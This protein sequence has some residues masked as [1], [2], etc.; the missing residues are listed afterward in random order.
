MLIKIE[1]ADGSVRLI[2]PTERFFDCKPEELVDKTKRLVSDTGKCYK[3]QVHYGET[4]KVNINNE[5]NA[6][7]LKPVISP[8][9][10]I[11]WK[12]K[13]LKLIKAMKKTTKMSFEIVSRNG[14]ASRIVDLKNKRREQKRKAA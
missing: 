10:Y 8:S 4:L 1:F 14:V 5:R 3:A 11:D 12:K 6:P 2:K 9:T 7:Q 13:R